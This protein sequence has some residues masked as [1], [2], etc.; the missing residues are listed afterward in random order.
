M[1]DKLHLPGEASWAAQAFI[2][3]SEPQGADIG[4]FLAAMTKEGGRSQFCHSAFR[5]GDHAAP[6]ARS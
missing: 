1:L 5:S 2:E 4:M 6:I 3:S